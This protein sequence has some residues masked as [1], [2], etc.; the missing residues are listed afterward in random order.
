MLANLYRYY[1]SSFR[2]IEDLFEEGKHP[3]FRLIRNHLALY[4]TPTLRKFHQT[5]V[6]VAPRCGTEPGFSFYK[7]GSTF[8]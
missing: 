5:V 8:L 1:I 2:D 3:L 4:F 7:T 6:K